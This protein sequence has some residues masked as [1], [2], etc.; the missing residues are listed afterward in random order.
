MEN[1]EKDFVELQGETGEVRRFFEDP[2]G[3]W[4]LE[5]DDAGWDFSADERHGFLTSFRP[6]QGPCVELG[7][8]LITHRGRRL[9][10]A[11][12]HREAGRLMLIMM[13]R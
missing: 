6:P 11:S 5:G 7:V 9:V 4:R 8:A 12:M 3:W 13:P 10:V 1:E 2:D